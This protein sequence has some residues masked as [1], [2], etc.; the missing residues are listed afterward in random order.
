[1]CP[2]YPPPPLSGG[3]SEELVGSLVSDILQRLPAN[4]DIEKAQYKYPVR[5][6]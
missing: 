4:F 2:P 3:S 6:A 1:M 5:Y